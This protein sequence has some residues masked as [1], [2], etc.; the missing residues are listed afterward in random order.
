VLTAYLLETKRKKIIR[1]RYGQR[2][3]LP[4]FLLNSRLTAR[5]AKEL[6]RSCKKT[7]QAVQEIIQ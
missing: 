7:V 2:C 1:S 5:P 4:I 3:S 6:R